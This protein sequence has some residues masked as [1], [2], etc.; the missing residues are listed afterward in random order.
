MYWCP[1][2]P[3]GDAKVCAVRLGKAPLGLAP[4]S[5]SKVALKLSDWPFANDR[6]VAEGLST[7]EAVPLPAEQRH[8]IDRDNALSLF[9][10]YA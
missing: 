5:A 6:V 3:E 4:D 9:P 10:Q 1:A 7:Y 2:L 8:A